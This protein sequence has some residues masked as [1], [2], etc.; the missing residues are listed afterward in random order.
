[1]INNAVIMGRIVADPELRTTANG[2]SVTSFTVAID[3]RFSIDN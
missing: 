2:T 1:M 3:R